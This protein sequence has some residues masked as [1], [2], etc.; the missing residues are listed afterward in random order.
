MDNR[1]TPLSDDEVL[2]VGSGRILMSNPTFKVGEFLDTLAQAIS[3]R[4][5]EWSE[6]HEGWFSEGL[7][8]DALRLNGGGWQRGRVRIRLEFSPSHIQESLPERSSARE[9]VRLRAKTVDPDFDD[10]DDM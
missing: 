10:F 1:F 6:D 7:D 3:D 5:E 8:C 9:R 4:E 2:Y